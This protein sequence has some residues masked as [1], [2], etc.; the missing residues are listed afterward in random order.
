MKQIQA[1]IFMVGLSVTLA[2][3][4]I[5]SVVRAD[6]VTISGTAC[7][8][9]ACVGTA[10]TECGLDA[11]PCGY[12]CSATPASSNPY[13]GCNGSCGCPT[14]SC[15]TCTLTT[16][17]NCP[18]E[19]VYIEG[20]QSAINNYCGCPAGTYAPTQLNCHTGQGDW[21]AFG[22][23]CTSPYCTGC[24]CSSTPPQ[25]SMNCPSEVIYTETNPSSVKNYCGCSAGQT[26]PNSLTCHTGTGSWQAFGASCT[27]P[28]CTGCSCN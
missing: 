2:M 1:K 27:A 21:Q 9:G 16:P 25:N 15:N 7:E 14:C 17:S 3:L 23:S 12:T 5:P 10:C 13:D 18:N 19:V 24:S 11:C 8:S 28:Y 20:N 4:V 6:C 26:A 22:L